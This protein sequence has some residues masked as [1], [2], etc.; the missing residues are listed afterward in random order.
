MQM[1]CLILELHILFIFINLACK[2]NR[3][4]EKLEQI[5][6]VNTRLE[7]VLL[8]TKGVKSVRLE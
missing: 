2:L 8:T 3:L 6:V 7:K 4:K 1:F 5:L